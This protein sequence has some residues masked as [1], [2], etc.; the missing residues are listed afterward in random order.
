M[1]SPNPYA[2]PKAPV[3]DA[4][5][6]DI[7][8]TV[9]ATRGQRLG[10]VMLD[11]IIA[12]TWTVP[13]IVY[14][15]IWDYAFHHEP[16]PYARSA[17]LTVL[18]FLLFTLVNCWFLHANGQ[19]IGKKLVGIR[20]ARLDDTV[21]DLGRVVLLR[22]APMSLASLVPGIGALLNLIDALMIFGSERRCLHDRIASTKVIRVRPAAA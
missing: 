14:L 16:V 6:L 3:A 7:G 10:A 5:D 18:G 8:H 21:P 13:L 22:Y 1:N 9:L 17:L 19:T 20:I 2:P 15:G 4:E 11:G 12:L